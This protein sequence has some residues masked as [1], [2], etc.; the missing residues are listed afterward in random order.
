MINQVKSGA[1]LTLIA[2]YAVAAGACAKVGGIIAV[3]TSAVASAAEGEFVRVG[4]FTLAKATGQ[5]W[6]QGA[7]IY[8][9]DTAKNCTTSASGNTLIGAATVAALSGDTVG[10]V[11]LD[12]AVR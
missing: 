10:V 11:L 4:E 1:I 2:P 6:T 9:D 8:W 3:A 7:K 5:A 12:G